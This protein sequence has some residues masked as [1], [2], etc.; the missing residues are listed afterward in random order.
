LAALDGD[1]RGVYRRFTDPTDNIVTD[2]VRQ[3]ELLAAKFFEVE[4]PAAG[5]EGFDLL[6]RG[7]ARVLVRVQVEEKYLVPEA[8]ALLATAR[9][10]ELSRRAFDWLVIVTFDESFLVEEAWQLPFDAVCDLAAP[11]AQPF[12]VTTELREHP[13]G[14]LLQDARGAPAATLRSGV[15]WQRNG[16]APHDPD[17]ADLYTLLLQDGSVSVPWE[18]WEELWNALKRRA[19]EDGYSTEIELT[20]VKLTA[21]L[22]AETIADP[23]PRLRADAEELYRRIQEE[24][25]VF[26]SALGGGY[27]AFADLQTGRW[28]AEAIKALAEADGLE[29]HRRRIDDVGEYLW[30]EPRS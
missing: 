15:R 26:T 5:D 3:A 30:L 25:E 14:E 21:P 19:A 10:I 2:L 13:R 17:V 24:G 6:A 28:E 20:T 8:R 1:R 12:S 4:R 23:I 27:H 11:G 9:E 18:A 29:L 16:C 7:G 22:R